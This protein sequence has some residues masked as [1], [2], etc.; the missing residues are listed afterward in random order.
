[1]LRDRFDNPSRKHPYLSNKSRTSLEGVCKMTGKV[2]Q[3]A[4]KLS[5]TRQN[6]SH[7]LIIAIKILCFELNVKTHAHQYHHIHL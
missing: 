2:Q 7:I 6:L 5:K 1:M 4:A 3:M